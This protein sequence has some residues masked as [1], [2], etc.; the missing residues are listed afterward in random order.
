MKEYE[1]YFEKKEDLKLGEEMEFSVR[2][3]ESFEEFNVRAIVG[4]KEEEGWDRLW[5]EF[6]G[7]LGIARTPYYI[8]ILEVKEEPE[9]ELVVKVDKTRLAQR[10]GG[11]IRSLLEKENEEK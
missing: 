10:R 2:D 7:M 5:V 11:M 1:V 9:V 8:K 3:K 4:D 6:G